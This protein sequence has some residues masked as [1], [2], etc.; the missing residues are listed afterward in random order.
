MKF[1]TWSTLNFF[2]YG[3]ISIQFFSAE[4]Y[5]QEGQVTKYSPLSMTSITSPVTVTVR[6]TATCGSPQQY[7]WNFHYCDSSSNSDTHRVGDTSPMYY[8]CRKWSR[9][10][11]QNSSLLQTC[12]NE[13][14]TR[15]SP[16]GFLKHNA[17]WLGCQWSMYSIHSYNY[18]IRWGAFK[19]KSRLLAPGSS[20]ERRPAVE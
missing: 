2:V 16:V 14:K 9:P 3:P 1:T 8:T 11:W 4:R 5:D 17:T 13:D 15:Q 12:D 6:F 20:L 19:V 7:C 18:F 10:W